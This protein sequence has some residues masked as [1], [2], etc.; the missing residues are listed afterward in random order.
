MN[1]R[2]R[3]L[4][5]RAN[6]DHGCELGDRLWKLCIV[7]S[8]CI[9]MSASCLPSVQA[10]RSH[11]SHRRLE[12]PKNGTSDIQRQMQ[13]LKQLQSLVTP[14]APTP[15]ESTP[16]AISPEQ[17]KRLSE[18]MRQF[19]GKIPEGLNIKPEDVPPGLVSELMSDPKSRQQIQEMLEQYARDRQIPKGNSQGG[20]S[21]L[22][23]Q[24]SSSS[25]PGGDGTPN[26]GQQSG[27]DRTA[28]NTES[29]SDGER[30]NRTDE[31]P[32][33]PSLDS[34]RQKLRDLERRL[35]APADKSE[36]SG[37]QAIEGGQLPSTERAASTGD[38]GPSKPNSRNA[39]QN[40][41]KRTAPIAPRKEP[42]NDAEWDA[43]LEELIA[44]QRGTVPG[45][46]DSEPDAPSDI[47]GPGLSRE[48]GGQ[49]P[50]AFGDSFG[51]EADQLDVGSVS[52]F[53]QKFKDV[54]SEALPSPGIQP[55]P[56]T[57]AEDKEKSV[58]D[59]QKQQQDAK[60]ELARNGFQQTLK[61][62][63][64]DAREQANA[65]ASASAAAGQQPS[66]AGSGIRQTL[67][68]AL[69]GVS[70][71][72]VEIAKDA[73]FKQPSRV[74]S[75]GN[76]NAPPSAVGSKSASNGT[77]TVGQLRKS[78]TE[79]FSDMAA[80]PKSA[81]ATPSR[82][83]GG[84][85]GGTTASSS[86]VLPFLFLTLAVAAVLAVLGLGIRNS[87]VSEHDSGPRLSAAG[88]QSKADVITA[89]HQMAMKPSRNT[90]P[91]WTHGKVVNDLVEQQPETTYPATV[92]GELYEQAR[93]LPAESE[94]TPAQINE[95]KS[96]L[97]RCER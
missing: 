55:T 87:R 70:E 97:K 58:V 21:V 50:A 86:N 72:I 35:S 33:L 14:D 83:S 96:A 34:I 66:S 79:F 8:A 93:Y 54:P 13:L 23:P 6:G 26:Q 3:T 39:N 2:N 40:S 76:T 69:G 24:K 30:Q 11:I 16:P 75:Q 91:W 53:L 67:M 71:K 73:K 12:L 62:I 15:G 5:P 60:R 52:D 95:A 77:T 19:G 41:S 81:A 29:N 64:R 10:Q 65:A 68:K 27:M 42:R 37:S 1:Q 32:E 89:F 17:L 44:R 85:D 57:P 45:N 61:N 88:I 22:P 9:L 92:L 25:Q 20:P 94:F 80:T 56:P 7:V 38:R 31:I 84:G 43:L 74:S 28:P 36:P 63:V 59:L 51:S 48:V 90:E 49:P 46:T 78:A 18:L 47:S 82:P 4:P